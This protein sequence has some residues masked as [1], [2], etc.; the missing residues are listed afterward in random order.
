M[1]WFDIY[2]AHWMWWIHADWKTGDMTVRGRLIGS[3]T[4]FFKTRHCS[5]LGKT[6]AVTEDGVG[7]ECRK[8][9]AVLADL[10]L[11]LHTDIC[12]GYCTKMQ[13][14]WPH[15][16]I[17]FL[18]YSHCT[19]PVIHTFLEQNVSKVD[20]EAEHW[21]FVCCRHYPELHWWYWRDLTCCSL[22]LGWVKIENLAWV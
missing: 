19:L 13:E 12:D 9:I 18:F 7:K 3:R 11:Q 1:D 10:K 16:Q 15:W 21:L 2:T 4:R 17:S 22:A 5:I 8:V 6:G 20:I 14:C